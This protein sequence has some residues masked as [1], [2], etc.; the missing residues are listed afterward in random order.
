MLCLL[1][2]L[3]TAL[4]TTKLC[5]QAL[6][7]STLKQQLQDSDKD[8]V[9][10][11]RD[12]C[13]DTPAGS[14]IDN[15]GC[16]NTRTEYYQIHFQI[17]FASADAKLQ[18]E[19]HQQITQIGQ[20]L[21]QNP[22]SIIC[23][24]GHTDNQGPNWF[25]QGLSYQRANAIAE[26]LVR[27]YGIKDR[28]ILRLAYGASRPLFENNNEQ[29]R[30]QNRR[31][32]GTILLPVNA[33]KNQWQIP[34]ALNQFRLNTE[35]KNAL[36]ELP[37]KISTAQSA[38]ILITGHTDKSG[39]PSLN[40]LLS[41][42]RAQQVAHY[43]QSITSLNEAQIK[44]KGYGA[45]RPI[46]LEDSLISRAKNRRVEVQLFEEPALSKQFIEAK[47]TIWSVDDLDLTNAPSPRD[48]PLFRPF[49]P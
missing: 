32:N 45:D 3:L 18:P 20:F 17:H 15:T 7:P 5:A 43:L 14:A 24:E 37:Q 48:L 41:E 29:N 13:P 30:F 27:Q 26:H 8:G 16:P 9:I 31:V 1:L 34:F 11:A 22:Q 38:F 23:L 4:S 44:V 40:Q 21:Q 12:L 47:W 49:Q 2:C 35:Q 6:Y 10:N 33:P 39:R 25:N 46:G 19:Q 42:K 28:R 36:A